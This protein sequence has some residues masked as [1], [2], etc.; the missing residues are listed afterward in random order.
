MKRR[1]TGAGLFVRAWCLTRKS[2]RVAGAPP[3]P[4]LR[5]E[6][7]LLQGH[8]V[9]LAAGIQPVPG[10]E[11]LHGFDRRVAPLTAGLAAKRAVFGQRLLNFG[12]AFGSRDLLPRSRR[13][14]CLDL[15]PR[16]LPAEAAAS[17]SCGGLPWCRSGAPRRSRCQYQRQA[18]GNRRTK[19]HLP[20]TIFLL[21]RK[22]AIQQ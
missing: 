16:D 8:R 19:S 17:R 20:S 7:Q 4:R 14:E 3:L 6:P 9:Q 12:N 10:L 5:T 13:L 15:F 22:A 21:S 1:V 18:R 11:L 2:R